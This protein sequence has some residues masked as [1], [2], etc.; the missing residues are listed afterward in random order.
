MNILPLERTHQGSC[1]RCIRRI[2]VVTNKMIEPERPA[3]VHLGKVGSVKPQKN[4]M[5]LV[6]MYYNICLSD[7]NAA[8]TQHISEQCGPSHICLCSEA[9]FRSVIRIPAFK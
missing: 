4:D 7:T 8:I 1:G 9:L 6:A 3:D 2:R 5:F